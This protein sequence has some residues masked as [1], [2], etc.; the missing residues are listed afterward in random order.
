MYIYVYMNLL[1]LI[2]IYIYTKKNIYQVSSI[3]SIK[4]IL[5][6]I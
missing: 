2:Y 4:N 1:I 3:Y 6:N 5:T